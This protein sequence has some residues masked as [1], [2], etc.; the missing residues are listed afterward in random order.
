MIPAEIIN[1]PS[2]END[3]FVKFSVVA[4]THVKNKPD[5]TLKKIRNIS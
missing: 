4:I 2:K 3:G 1:L 5:D